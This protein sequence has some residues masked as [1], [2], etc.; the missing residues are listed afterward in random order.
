MSLEH[1]PARGLRVLRKRATAAKVG[2]S[3]PHIYRLIGEG[4]FPAPIRLGDRSSGWLEN[5]LDDYLAGRIAERNAQRGEA[6]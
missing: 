1:A 3:V 6:A 2:L 5:E 4:K